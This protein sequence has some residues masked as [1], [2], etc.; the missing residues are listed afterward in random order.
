MA[1]S[2]QG[3]HRIARQNMHPPFGIFWMRYAEDSRRK[4]L[5]AI[6][7]S[8]CLRENGGEECVL[9]RIYVHIDGGTFLNPDIVHVP[10]EGVNAKG[11]Q[12]VEQLKPEVHIR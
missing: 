10:L 8:P 5:N 7:Q 1:S 2:K 9:K 12:K 6:R 4:E 11:K 3:L